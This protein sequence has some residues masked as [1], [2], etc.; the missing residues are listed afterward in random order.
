MAPFDHFEMF[1]IIDNMSVIIR[2]NAYYAF[3]FLAVFV[4]QLL[5]GLQTIC[6]SISSTL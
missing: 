3:L 6:I 2:F 1:F 4:E 5:L